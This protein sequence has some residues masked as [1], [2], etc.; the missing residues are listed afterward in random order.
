M[1]VLITINHPAHVY[2]FKAIIFSLKQKGHGIKVVATDKEMSFALLEEL[3]IEY[4]GLGKHKNKIIGKVLNFGKRWFSLF[5]FCLKFKPDVGMGIADFYVSQVSWVLRFKSIIFTDTDH[6]VHDPYITFPFADFIITP[7]CFEK[8]LGPRH[9]TYDGYHE[10]A[11]LNSGFE[12]EAEIIKDLGLSINERFAIIRLVAWNAVHD[13]GFKGIIEKSL[14]E[15]I[16]FL[17]PK[18]KVYISSEKV[19]DSKYER[20]RIRIPFCQ[21]HS[22][23]YFASI[24][25]GEGGTM[26]SEAAILGTPSIYINELQ[27]GYIKELS[28]EF[29]IVFLPKDADEIIGTIKEIEK[30]SDTYYK[31]IRTKILESKFNTTNFVIEFI[32][33]LE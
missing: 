20:Y 12:P 23:L 7:K 30:R 5:I 6:V 13:I 11:Y 22:A 9:V 1:K 18:Y 2:F 19:M 17:E 4:H 25:I 24:Y 15:L 31:T 28:H 3:E 14:D 29:K 16:A 10:L 8:Q 33:A 27:M 21:I 26:A 32:E